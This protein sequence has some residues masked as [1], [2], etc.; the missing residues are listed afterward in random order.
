[1]VSSLPFL[2]PIF[3]KKAKEYRSKQFSGSG[4]GC[5]KEKGGCLGFRSSER[6]KLS[7]RG[8]THSVFISTDRNRGPATGSIDSML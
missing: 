6:Y 5:D 3:I 1:M 7:D 2:A 8:N 4:S